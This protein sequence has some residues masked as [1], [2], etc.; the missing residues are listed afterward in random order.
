[1]SSKSYPQEVKNHRDG[2]FCIDCKTRKDSR[3]CAKC[4]KET[5]SL[6]KVQITE[7]V[8]ARESIGMKQKRQGFKS[9]IKKIFQG[10]KPSG[11]PWFADGVDVQM[12][13]DRE[14]KEY[15]QIVKDN[16]TGEIIHEEHEPLDQHKS[17]NEKTNK[18]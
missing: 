17:K 18:K 14:K 9:F 4:E 3:F 11:D 5:S 6:F 7:T 16:L 2:P 12:I 8:K 15:H 13:I 10:Y 1:M